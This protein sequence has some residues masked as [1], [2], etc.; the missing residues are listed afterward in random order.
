MGL[1]ASLKIG[2]A[3]GLLAIAGFFVWDYRA[4]KSALEETRLELATEKEARRFADEARRVAIDEADRQA[5]RAANVRTRTITIRKRPD[6]NETAADILL[7]T[8]DGLRTDAG[9]DTP[10]SD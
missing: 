4:T 2:A 9:G 8:I 10:G 1:L 5:D 3:I 6:G 7:D